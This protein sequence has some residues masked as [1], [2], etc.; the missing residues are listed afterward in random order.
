MTK[1]LTAPQIKAALAAVPQW[2]KQGCNITRTREFEDFVSAI[3]FVNRVAKLAEQAG[4]HP[5][6][7]IRWNKVVLT[8]STHDAG[9]LTEKDFSLA[10]RFDRE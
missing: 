2:K 8:L 1:K 4:H 9:G 10:A 3:K 5:D 6:I 7:D